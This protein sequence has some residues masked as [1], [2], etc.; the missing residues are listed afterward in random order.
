[1]LSPFTKYE[2]GKNVELSYKAEYLEGVGLSVLGGVVGEKVA[3]TS[4]AFGSTIVAFV[5]LRVGS[6]VGKDWNLVGTAVGLI[7]KAR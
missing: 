5:G 4:V 3:S 7:V 2:K 1:M 6:R